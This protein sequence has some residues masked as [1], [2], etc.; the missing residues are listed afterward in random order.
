MLGFSLLAGCLWLSPISPAYADSATAE[1]LFRAGRMAADAGDHA[2]AAAR[3][4]ESQRLDPAPGT[5]LNLAVAEERLSR[6]ASAF[7]HASAAMDGLP[8]GDARIALA[9]TLRARLEPRV[10]RVRI[11]LAH[12]AP[13]GAVVKRDDIELGAAAL[14]LEL[15]IDPGPHTIVVTAKGHRP[16]TFTLEA[17][18]G[19]RMTIDVAPGAPEASPSS[20]GGKPFAETAAIEPPA[21]PASAAPAPPAP[22]T[23][24]SEP[25]RTSR[26]GIGLVVGGGA[27]LVASG[28][29]GALVLQKKAVV[30]DHCPAKRCDAEGLAAGDS[31]RTLS[32]ASTIAFGVGVAATGVGVYLLVRKGD[33]AGRGT[34]ALSVGPEQLSLTGSF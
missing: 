11:R 3:F 28:V 23:P 26:A 5:L 15:P 30:A 22:S 21:L 16:A 4:A 19:A 29:L 17:K 2:T 9:R 13:P 34:A 8:K 7:D 12:D 33:G 32:L 1:A 14:G 27:A 10:P 25:P 18:E 24:P 6:F 31:G 20:S